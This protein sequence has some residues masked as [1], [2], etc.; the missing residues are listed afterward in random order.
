MAVPS[1]VT[2]DGTTAQLLPQQ[3][4]VRLGPPFP[5]RLRQA[6]VPVSPTQQSPKEWK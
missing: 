5:L 4:A 2:A 6:L 3:G 1:T